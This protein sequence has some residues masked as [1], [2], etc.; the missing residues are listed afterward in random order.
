ML[1]ATDVKLDRGLLWY[2][3]VR[4]TFWT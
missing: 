3:S 1:T 4:R 2:A